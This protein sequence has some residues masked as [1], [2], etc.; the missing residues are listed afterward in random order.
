M[1]KAQA[2]SQFHGP[3]E[4]N[5]HQGWYQLATRAASNDTSHK[6]PAIVRDRRRH[7]LKETNCPDHWLTNVPLDDVYTT[8]CTSTL[9]PP[10]TPPRK[11]KVHHGCGSKKDDGRTCVREW[12]M[13]GGLIDE[14]GCRKC[15]TTS[16]IRDSA[17]PHFRFREGQKQT[18]LA[19]GTRNQR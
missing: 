3:T 13:P 1:K 16:T 8:P 11:V 18:I 6:K 5:L 15:R 12:R 14:K 2:A 4:Q 17:R 9:N 19:K 7:T 10:A